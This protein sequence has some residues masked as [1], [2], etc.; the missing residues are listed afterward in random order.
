MAHLNKAI[1]FRGSP[2]CTHRVPLVHHPRRSV[3]VTRGDVAVHG[4]RPTRASPLWVRFGQ[5]TP[6]RVHDLVRNKHRVHRHRGRGQRVDDRAFRG[7]DGEATVRPLITGN[8]GIEE[9]GESKIDRGVGVRE[10]A[11]LEPYHLRIARTEVGGDR[12]A[13]D[14]QRDPDRHVDLFEAIIVAVV[15]TKVRAVG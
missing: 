8:R 11:V 4:L 13:F 9:R 1:A 2:R 14:G 5:R 6:H 7:N 15:L 10:R 3:V 12:I